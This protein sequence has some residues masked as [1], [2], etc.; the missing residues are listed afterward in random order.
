[1][2]NVLWKK[3]YMN[4]YHA[5]NVNELFDFLCLRQEKTQDDI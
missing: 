5:T 1:M 2:K 4:D 3:M